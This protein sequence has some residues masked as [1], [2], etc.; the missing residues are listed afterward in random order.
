MLKALGANLLRLRR[1]LTNY[2]LAISAAFPIW[3]SAEVE[4]VE[5]VIATQAGLP[6]TDIRHYYEDLLRLA[7]ERTRA[8][9]GDYKIIYANQ[10]SG[11]E[12]ERAM[13]I[14]D[15]G[16]TVIWGSVTPERTAQMLVVPVDLVKN[17][18]SYR[19]LIISADQQTRF[20]KIT[21]LNDLRLL[22]VGT[23]INWANNRIFDDNGIKLVTSGSFSGLFKMLAAGRV[24]YV[25]RAPYEILGE[26]FDYSNYKVKLEERLLLQ[27]TQPLN[28]SFFVNKHNTTL[29]N[30]LERGLRLAQADGSFDALFFHYPSFA[31]GYQLVKN[32]KLKIISLNASSAPPVASSHQSN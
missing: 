20:D 9:D 14:S 11:P 12:R 18:N 32:A 7:L 21:T 19:A 2:I 5:V 6:P 8:T 16:L 1:S 31:Y 10:N 28:Y 30:R 22:T 17:L 29:A 25:A 26:I 23:G 13:V 3:A 15:T 4:P 24:D 27:F